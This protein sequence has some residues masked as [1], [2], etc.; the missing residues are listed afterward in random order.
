MRTF[1]IRFR[2]LLMNA[3]R[4]ATA[5]NLSYSESP[6]VMLWKL[7]DCLFQ[8]IIGNCLDITIGI[9]FMTTMLRTFDHGKQYSIK[10][11]YRKYKIFFA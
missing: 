2:Y 9:C 4:K 7:A 1:A 8:L 10:L 5:S 3:G 6:S 11:F